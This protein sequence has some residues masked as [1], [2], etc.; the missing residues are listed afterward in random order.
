MELALAIICLLLVH[1]PV[2]RQIVVSDSYLPSFI[3]V[4]EGIVTA[5]MEDTANGL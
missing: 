5:T 1:K 4:R 2:L 3:G